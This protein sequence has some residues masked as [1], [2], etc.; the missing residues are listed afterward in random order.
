MQ[1]NHKEAF[2]RDSSS[3]EEL[4]QEEQADKIN[5]A[6]NDPHLSHKNFKSAINTS[7]NSG[8]SS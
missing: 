8:G 5:Y 2:S 6:I 3:S 7:H 4:D 1:E